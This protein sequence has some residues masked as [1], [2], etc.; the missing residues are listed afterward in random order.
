MVGVG[1]VAPDN[2]VDL[3]QD[4]RM[5]LAVKNFYQLENEATEVTPKVETDG[6][7]S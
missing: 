4:H 3:G 1:Q 2:Q 7:S 5:A 6:F